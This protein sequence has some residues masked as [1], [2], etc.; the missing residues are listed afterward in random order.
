M[1]FEILED[2]FRP[3]VLVAIGRGGYTPA[4]LLA[5]YLG[6]RNL[7]SFRMEHYGAG[8]DKKDEA[9]VAEPL[10]MDLD[11]QAVLIADDVNDTGESLIGAVDHVGERGAE[12]IRTA[13]LHEK[14]GSRT[15][16]DYVG[17]FMEEWRWIT[18]PWAVIEDVG[19]FL[20]QLDPQ[21]ETVPE[22]AR[23]LEEELD[24]RVP[25]QVIEDVLR[26]RKLRGEGS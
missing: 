13:V 12:E 24:L 23:R 6:V 25:E 16:A 21:P 22:A 15:E 18:Y 5:D 10:A 14:E 7:V 26:L 1:A 9:R 3:D 19:E 2:G 4:R 17:R 8:A 20:R 11:G